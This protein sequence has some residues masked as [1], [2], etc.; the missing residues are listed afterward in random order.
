MGARPRPLRAPRRAPGFNVRHFYQ[1]AR[2]EHGVQVS[3][4]FVKKAVQA[5][6]RV[7]L[8]GVA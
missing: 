5:G 7:T 4:S 1:I 2:R 6:A 8:E 3:Y